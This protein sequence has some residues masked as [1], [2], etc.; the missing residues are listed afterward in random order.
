M[1]KYRVIR[2][3]CWNSMILGL[4]TNSQEKKAINLFRKLES[5]SSLDPDFVSFIGVLTACNHSGLVDSV[6]EYFSLMT[7]TYNIKP[8]VQH[9]SCMVDVLGGTG[10]LEEPE[11]LI[12]GMPIPPDAIIW[13]SLL[14]SITRFGYAEMAERAARQLNELDPSQTSSFVL[15][16]NV[17]ASSGRYQKAI[18]QR[19][20]LKQKQIEKVPGC[21]LIELNGKVHEFVA[22][23]TLHP[24]TAKI[25]HA[26]DEM[27]LQQNE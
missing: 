20:V 19:V 24:S 25:Y 10:F 12:K 5:S 6:K 16:S 21:S 17:Y 14:S 26:L 23:G 8:S 9:Y 3:S 2:L 27:L 4:A 15:M 11:E 18:E 22:G 1:C 7:E 13:G